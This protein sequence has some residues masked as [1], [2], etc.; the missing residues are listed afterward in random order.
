MAS[1]MCP[2]CGKLIVDEVVTF[3]RGTAIGFCPTETFGEHLHTHC[4]CGYRPPP[5]PCLDATPPESA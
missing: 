5:R 3:C 1:T 4:F 2:K